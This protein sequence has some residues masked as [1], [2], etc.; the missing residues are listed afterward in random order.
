MT[1]PAKAGQFG[2]MT[3]PDETKH[4]ISI[5]YNTNT[6]LAIYWQVWYFKLCEEE[7]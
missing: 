4:I 2:R 6:I 7:L 1:A 5:F 3:S